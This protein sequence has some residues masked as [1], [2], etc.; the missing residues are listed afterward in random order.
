VFGLDGSA[1]HDHGGFYL[2]GKEKIV[3]EEGEHAVLT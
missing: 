3:A 1:G 2:W